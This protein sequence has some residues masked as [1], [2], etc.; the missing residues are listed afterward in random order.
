M[1]PAGFQ[2]LGWHDIQR[3][4]E[5]AREEDDTIE[6]KSA[7]KTGDDYLAFNE[8]QRERSLDSLAREVLAFLNTRGGDV[9]VGLTE[10]QNG[11]PVAAE[12]SKIKNAQ[13]TADRV[14]R[15][16]AA[17]IE[18]AQTNIAVRAIS[19]PEDAANGVIVIRVQPS[20]R[21]PH[22]SKR[23]RECYSRRGSESVPMAMDEIQDVTINR[24]RLRLEQSELLDNQFADFLDGRVEH[25]QFSGQF[26]H[27]RA[28][29]QPI[30]EQVIT[31]DDEL[32][33]RLGNVDQ[34]YYE[35]SG[36]SRVND[37]AFRQLYH[38]WRPILRGQKREYYDEFVETSHTDFQFA[39]KRVKESGILS[40]DYAVSSH[41]DGLENP[42]VHFEWLAGFFA[43][44]CANIAAI[45]EFKPTVLPATIRVG[46]R[47]AGEMRMNY[48]SGMWS[49][50]YEIPAGIF[51]PP[52]FT[53][54]QQ[55]DLAVFFRQI[56]I[57]LF[58][59]FNVRLD[60]PYSLTPPEAETS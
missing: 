9:I 53:I 38:A 54:D 60:Q 51:F 4:I 28:V 49:Q 47:A 35:Q 5:T 44:I 8:A 34:P 3:L 59:I 33:L 50:N 30:L 18:P 46:F 23:T 12:I 20:V 19:D 11:P 10:A 27:V 13:E 6:F 43:Q 58:S 37:V 55:S 26:V 36:Q 15:A 1:I 29:L 45:C 32:L 2:E 17:V 56:Q 39:A 52:D 7:F 22:R 42:L 25:R 14:A 41:F 31:V 24:T 48:G 21:A 16:L 40:F 57:D